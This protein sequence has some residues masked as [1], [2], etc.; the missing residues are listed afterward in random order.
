MLLILTKI[1]DCQANFELLVAALQAELTS[2][3]V[4]RRADEQSADV[5]SLQF[6]LS[7]STDRKELSTGTHLKS[8]RVRRMIHNILSHNPNPIIYIDKLMYCLVGR[9]R[10]S[11]LWFLAFPEFDDTI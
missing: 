3:E 2:L 1:D 10:F 7:S 5:K 11:P 6:D 9:S 8:L 4:R